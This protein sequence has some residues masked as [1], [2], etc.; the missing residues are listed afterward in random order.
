MG[1]VLSP[2]PELTPEA[3]LQNANI[4]MHHAIRAGGNRMKVFNPRMFQLAVEAMTLERDL[5]RGIERD[6]F[7]LQYQPI[8]NLRDDRL[9]G[10]E[11]VPGTTLRGRCPGPVHTPW[12]RNPGTS[13]T[14]G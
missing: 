8:V 9:I 6:E 12:P 10:F 11:Q 1:I 14:S 4:A 7:F 5:R 2:P 13:S 3:V